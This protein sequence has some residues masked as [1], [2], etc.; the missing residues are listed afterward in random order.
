MGD[1]IIITLLRARSN[2]AILGIEAPDTLPM[3][4]L[5]M[6]L[7]HVVTHYHLII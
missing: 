2:L 7:G 5:E 1:D 6:F 4:R 3:H